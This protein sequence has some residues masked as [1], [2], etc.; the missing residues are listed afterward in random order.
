MVGTEVI[1]FKISLIYWAPLTLF[2]QWRFTVI[3]WT[4][5]SRLLQESNWTTW[6]PLRAPITIRGQLWVSNYAATRVEFEWVTFCTRKA[7]N[8]LLSHHTLAFFLSFL[9]R[10]LSCRLNESSEKTSSFQA[11][12][13]GETKKRKLVEHE[14]SFARG[15]RQIS[16]S[17]FTDVVSSSSATDVVKIDETNPAGQ[18]IK[19]FNTATD[20]VFNFSLHFY[21]FL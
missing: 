8:L 13:P 17:S 3:V 9:C 14:E 10:S 16:S 21:C 18:F 6:Q 12:S 7:P 4:D 11:S 19:L 1:F 2:D 15:G 20:K 5:D